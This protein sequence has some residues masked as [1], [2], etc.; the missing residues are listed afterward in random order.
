MGVLPKQRKTPEAGAETQWTGTS[1]SISQAPACPSLRHPGLRLAFPAP[2]KTCVP[3]LPSFSQGPLTLRP[4]RPQSRGAPA[5]LLHLL[6]VGIRK[7]GSCG[8][9]KQRLPVLAPTQTVP[10][11]VA[12]VDPGGRRRERE[13]PG[14]F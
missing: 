2:P 12:V 10:T 7:L 8:K 3:S 6:S 1:N 14:G 5:R 4:P 11:P 9:E 13:P